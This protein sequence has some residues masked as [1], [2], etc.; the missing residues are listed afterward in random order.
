MIN[1]EMWNNYKDQINENNIDLYKKLKIINGEISLISKGG[2]SIDLIENY[3]EDILEQGK[4][5]I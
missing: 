5:L 2:S 3:I 4:E 1:L